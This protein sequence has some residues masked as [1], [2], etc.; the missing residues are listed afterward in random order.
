LGIAIHEKVRLVGLMHFVAIDASLPIIH[1]GM[2]VGLAAMGR[3]D[4][5]MAF[6]AGFGDR[7]SEKRRR[8]GPM[9][10]MAGQTSPPANRFV[11]RHTFR[12]QLMAVLAELVD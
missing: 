9:W 12:A 4:P 3:D 2:R 6:H 7:L 10:M 1:G 8:G 11:N 5:A